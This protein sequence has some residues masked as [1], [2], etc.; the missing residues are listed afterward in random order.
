MKKKKI[1]NEVLP[2]LISQ[3]ITY[4]DLFFEWWE[5]EGKEYFMK[6]LDLKLKERARNGKK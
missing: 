3:I 4:G 5:K 6:F 1:F 2:W